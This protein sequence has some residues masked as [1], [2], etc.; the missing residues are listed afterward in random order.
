MKSLLLLAITLLS[1]ANGA[2]DNFKGV[3]TLWGSTRTTYRRALAWA[4]IFTFLG[5][6][7]SAHWA[8]GLAPKFNGSTLLAKEIST[9]PSFLVAVALAAAATVWLASQLG[10]PTSTTH[11]LTGALVGAGVT[12]AGIAHVNFAPLDRDIILP[13]L[14]SPLLSVILTLAVY[15]LVLRASSLAASR[16][17]LCVDEPQ[18]V[19][20]ARDGPSGPSFVPVLRG[21]RWAPASECHRR[22]EIF[23][24]N[25]SEMLHWL[26]GAAISFA[27]G[28]NDTPKI[29]ALLL[30][31]SPS[32]G[33]LNYLLVALVIS[34]GGLLG[35]MR[36][37]QTLSRKITPMAAPEAVGANL[38]A[39][40]LVLLAS[41][42]ALPVST[43]HLTAGSLFGIGL[44]RRN[45][46]DWSRVGGILLSWLA[47]LPL[48][49]L[50]AMGFYR[51]LAI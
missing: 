16:D 27:R 20:L 30:V 39:A 49:A 50:L 28:L 34:L 15:P 8:A 41:A 29:V 47:T 21:M 40:M 43:T 10:L 12:S 19:A 23:H 4:T 13:L 48:G 25:L 46:A 1:F 14:L 44:L 32:T 45:E 18:L 26:S 51:L 6:L 42:W 7:L 5:S 17:C 38:A 22:A 37:A 9:Q 11:A 24:W 35:A 3:A 2:N 36:V 33:K 31:S